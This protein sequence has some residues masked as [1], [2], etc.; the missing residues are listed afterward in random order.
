M[1]YWSF[2][3]HSV[4]WVIVKLLALWSTVLPY[5]H[6]MSASGDK[7]SRFGEMSC[8]RNYPRSSLRHSRLVTHHASE[9]VVTRRRDVTSSS[10]AAA[11][12][13]SR[14]SRGWPIEMLHGVTR[15]AGWPA[16][17]SSIWPRLMLGRTAIAHCP[18]Y[19]QLRRCRQTRQD[20]RR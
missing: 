4:G 13:S 14:S 20:W 19:D 18:L 7:T 12:A 1:G 10:V 3:S 17:D 11:V 9:V 5:Y 6:I 16:T 15:R 2:L 8:C